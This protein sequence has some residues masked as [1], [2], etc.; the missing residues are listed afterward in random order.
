MLNMC[1]REGRCFNRWCTCIVPRSFSRPSSRR[2]HLYF[3]TRARTRT[4]HSRSFTS[5]HFRPD[6]STLKLQV[7]VLATRNR[8]LSLRQTRHNTPTPSSLPKYRAN[9]MIL[10]VVSITKKKVNKLDVTRTRG[11]WVDSSTQKAAPRQ[12][13]KTVWIASHL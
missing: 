8:T 1:V 7:Q 3:R 6:S 2:H 4:P 5:S 9:T 11:A 13:L 10:L 12:G